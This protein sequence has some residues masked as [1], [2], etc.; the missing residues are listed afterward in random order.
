MYTPKMGTKNEIAV[1]IS[2][3]IAKAFISIYKNIFTKNSSMC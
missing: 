2:A 3:T 1:K